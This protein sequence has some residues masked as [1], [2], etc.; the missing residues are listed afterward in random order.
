LLNSQREAGGITVV[1]RV[2]G[3]G[4]SSSRLGTGGC[5]LGETDNRLRREELRVDSGASGRERVSSGAASTGRVG[6]GGGVCGSS[7][8]DLSKEGQ[9]GSV[10]ES[11]LHLEMGGGDKMGLLDGRM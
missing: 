2:E 6:V 7:H 11:G 9:D 10:S 5:R 4:L 1:V 8:G 3:S